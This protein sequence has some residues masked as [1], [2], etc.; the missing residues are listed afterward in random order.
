MLAAVVD[1]ETRWVL[2]GLVSPDAPALGDGLLGVD[3]DR[4]DHHP[5]LDVERAP[6]HHRRRH[7][8]QNPKKL[9]PLGF[10]RVLFART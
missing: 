5:F 3:V 6:I 8:F 9:K 10:A 2:A 4:V 7:R 1:L